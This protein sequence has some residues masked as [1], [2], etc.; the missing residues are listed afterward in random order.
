MLGIENR[1]YKNFDE[2]DI[3]IIKQKINYEKVN[4]KIEEYSLFSKEWLVNALNKNITDDI[5]QS[6]IKIKNEIKNINKEY[7]KKH[8][9]KYFI[10]YLSYTSK[11][12]LSVSKKQKLH[13]KF[14][15]DLFKLRH[16][17]LKYIQ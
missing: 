16:K 1:L 4:K 14:K 12:L 9:F 3:E 11:Y 2:I 10:K 13:N 5:V 17:H 7:A 6:K 8:R 15:K